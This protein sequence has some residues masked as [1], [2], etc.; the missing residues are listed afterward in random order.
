VRI[1]GNDGTR[2]DFRVVD[3][4]AIQV[5]KTTN[6]VILGTTLTTTVNATAPAGSSRVWTIPDISANGTFAALEASQTFSGTTNTFSGDLYTVTWTDYSGSSTIVGWTTPTAKIRYKKI[7]KLVWVQYQIT[8][9]SNAGT[10]SFT[11]P[12]ANNASIAAGQR[13]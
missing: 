1:Y 10:T 9:T 4:G 3:T 11:L 5:F 7:G 2:E 8:G 13:R 12:F 6:Q